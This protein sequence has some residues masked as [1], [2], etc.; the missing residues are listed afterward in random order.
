VARPANPREHGTLRGWDQHRYRH[1]QPC[2]AC[3][4]IRRAAK[5]LLQ[6]RQQ[7]KGRCAPGLGWPLVVTRA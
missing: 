2:D 1:E 5:Q 4:A 7:H 3:N 6:Y